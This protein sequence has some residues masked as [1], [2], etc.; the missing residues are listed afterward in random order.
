MYDLELQLQINYIS[1]STSIADI[2]TKGKNLW[3]LLGSVFWVVEQ[4]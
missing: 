4:C 1:D 2:M 3:W